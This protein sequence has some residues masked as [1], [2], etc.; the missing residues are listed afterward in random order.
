MARPR[1]DR[2]PSRSE[3][4]PGGGSA[5]PPLRFEES[6]LPRVVLSES[7]RRS[8]AGVGVPLG[9]WQQQK[10]KKS[11]ASRPAPRVP[12]GEIRESAGILGAGGANKLFAIQ[13][14]HLFHLRPG[15]GPSKLEHV[16]V[17]VLPR[18]SRVL[19]LRSVMAT[20]NER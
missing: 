6:E 17:A 9:P 12:M 13:R 7:G 19:I 1:A 5:P 14:L 20:N 16:W 2:S 8:P 18:R 15:P 11:D 3:Q 4:G 10:L